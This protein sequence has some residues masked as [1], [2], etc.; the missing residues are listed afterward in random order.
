M[1]DSN[2]EVFN[3]LAEHW[4][5]AIVTQIREMEREG[6][7]VGVRGI[8]TE[9][10][11]RLRALGAQVLSLVLS[12]VEGTPAA[13]QAC[14]CGGTL[15]YQR[16]RTAEVVS[17]FG[18]VT[19]RRG[20]YAECDCGHGQAPIDEQFGLQPGAVTAGLAE[21]LALTGIELSF[22]GG[23]EW[24][25]KFLLFRVSESTV[26]EET[27]RFGA[28]QAEVDEQ[29]SQ[30]GQSADELQALQRREAPTCQRVYGSLDAAKVRIE[31]RNLGEKAAPER[32]AWRDLKL[33]CWFEAEPVRPAQRSARQRT[34]VERDQPALRATAIEY[35]TDIA[36]AEAF[37]QLLWGTGCQR[38]AE[39]VAEVIFVCDGAPWIWKLVERYYPD[40]VQIVDWYHA[41]DCLKQVALSAFSLELE[42]ATW[43]DQTLARLWAGHL[44][45][46]IAAC[47][48]VA[49][50]SDEARRAVGYFTENQPRMRYADF[51]ARD[52][53]IG[54]GT[55]ESACKQIVAHRL[56]RSGA[57]WHLAG[58][59]QTA[60]AR[61]AWLSGSWDA[62]ARQRDGLPLAA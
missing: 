24:L 26:R 45:E 44:S 58:A 56:K 52:Y 43:L 11:Q 54:S 33:G 48:A 61:A 47:Q 37:G 34:K 40:A 5:A 42:R 3:R 59:T 50:R 10:R 32:E 1:D 17:V 9:I 55:V 14:G 31:P 51:R 46:V 60:K 2:I 21:L 35:F 38:Q 41:A 13:T 6:Q 20:Y 27:E 15:H 57:Q 29:Q 22:A 62:L 39:R 25:E 28:L 18:P 36:P 8:E 16:R 4:T 23:A 30:I 12:R 19:Y 53:F 7:R 49:A